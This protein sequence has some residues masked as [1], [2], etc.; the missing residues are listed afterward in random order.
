MLVAFTGVVILI[1]ICMKSVHMG[2]FIY[3]RIESFIYLKSMELVDF[4]F[5]VFARCPGASLSDATGATSIDACEGMDQQFQV[6]TKRHRS[7]SRS[8][9]FQDFIFK[10]KFYFFIYIEHQNIL[11][12]CT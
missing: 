1:F 7:L 8:I 5:P 10:F 3:R 2:Y 11:T 6:I 9:D 4:D 12:A